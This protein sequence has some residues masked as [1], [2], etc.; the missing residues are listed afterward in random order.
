MQLLKSRSRRVHCSRHQLR[1]VT[2][3]Q[4]DLSLKRYRSCRDDSMVTRCSTPSIELPSVQNRKLLP[5]KQ[6]VRSVALIIE[7]TP[8]LTLSHNIRRI[9][10]KDRSRRDKYAFVRDQDAWTCSESPIILKCLP[11]HHG[12]RPHPL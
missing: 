4:L 2:F 11:A 7:V 3:P 6:K 12:Y 10:S 5:E 8:Y 9:P 1:S